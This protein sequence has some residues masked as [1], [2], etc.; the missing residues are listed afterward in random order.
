MDFDVNAAKAA[1]HTDEDIARIQKGIADA[2]AAGHSDEDIQ[3]YLQTQESAPPSS[4]PTADE[5]TSGVSKTDTGTYTTAQQALRQAGGALRDTV[6]GAA[7]LPDLFPA[8]ATGIKNFPT[9]LQN[10]LSSNAEGYNSSVSPEDLRTA[11][12][13]SATPLEEPLKPFQHL[14]NTVAPPDPAHPEL[15][16]AFNTA[17]AVLPAV[18]AGQPELAMD[19]LPAI[20]AETG[21]TTGG[22]YG[23]GV[24]GRGVDQYFGGT[25]DTGEQVGSFVGGFGYPALG[26]GL[27]AAGRKMWVDPVNSPIRVAQ[28][29]QL[30]V[31]LDM[32]LVG[33][34]SAAASGKGSGF[35]DL[36]K[37]QQQA[38]DAAQRGSATAIRGSESTAPIATGNVGVD[39]RNTATDAAERARIDANRIYDPMSDAAGRGT[40]LDPAPA[41]QAIQT[42]REDPRTSILQHPTL[43]NYERLIR[44]DSTQVIDP[45]LES[46]LQAQ[47][48]RATTNLSNAQPGSPLATAAQKSLD[49]LDEQILKNRGF[50]WN[51]AQAI[52]SRGGNAMDRTKGFDFQTEA[53]V[54]AGLDESLRQRAAQV[55]YDQAPFDYNTVER[56]FGHLKDDQAK[57]AALG[58]KDPGPAYNAVLQ[59]GGEQN[60]PLLEQLGLH[61]DPSALSKILADNLELKGRGPVAAGRPTLPDNTG[62]PA[63][64]ADWWAKMPE[65]SKALYTGL[66]AGR[67]SRLP[68]AELR[69]RI[70][71]AFNLSRADAR[72]GGP[73]QV[74]P[75]EA[76]PGKGIAVAGMLSGS[77]GMI[78]GGLTPKIS[79]FLFGKVLR[80]EPVTRRLVA[81]NPGLTPSDLARA[82]SA[83]VGSQ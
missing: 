44:G 14:V 8:I 17:G 54:H 80:S 10:S 63:G 25:G 15:R 41:N 42:I 51:Q 75:V 5:L 66:D 26:A 32:T 24:I 1:G 22:S 61:A 47:R 6:E 65:E 70:D 7:K 67:R 60:Y 31:P 72:R 20:V 12:P 33:N 53:G 82:M 55:G 59:G 3:Q 36:R 45:T 13:P 64:A 77:P 37:Q 50:S 40:V 46:T 49:D 73:M 58:E 27:T 18:L 19:S 69:S 62:L 2:R 35:A 57:L 30:G 11:A 79:N 76:Y 56:E 16:K 71:A 29:D 21:I 81:G 28:A 38:I 9:R 68:D 78:A 43:D 52:K 48:Q 83:A 23:G 74:D 34:D 39:I 4:A